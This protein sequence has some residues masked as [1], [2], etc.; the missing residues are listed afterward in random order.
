MDN[1]INVEEAVQYINFLDN[2]VKRAYCFR[3]GM[4]ICECDLT[5]DTYKVTVKAADPDDDRFCNVFENKNGEAFFARTSKNVANRLEVCRINGLPIAFVD[6]QGEGKLRSVG[7][8][9]QKIVAVT[10][11]A[12]LAVFCES[13]AAEFPKAA[14][15]QGEVSRMMAEEIGMDEDELGAGQDGSLRKKVS[16]KRE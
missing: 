6:T 3:G 8:F 9:G 5:T 2:D 16:R 7:L 15:G 10:D 1:L 13:G 12:H 11:E 14:A 4:D